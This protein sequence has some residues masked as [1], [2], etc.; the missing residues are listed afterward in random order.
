[1]KI[2][3][4]EEHFLTPMYREH[5]SATEYRNFYLSSRGEA[6]GHDIVEQNLDLGGQRIAH[7]DAAGVDM[8]VLSFGSPGPQ[9]FAAEVAIP[10]ARD[11][12]QRLFETISDLTL[13]Q[14]L[15]IRQLDHEPLQ[16]GQVGQGALH[17][18]RVLRIDDRRRH[19]AMRRGH[20]VN[21]GRVVGAAAAGAR[22]NAPKLVD[23][24]GSRH[25]QQP[26]PHSAARGV[27]ACRLSPRLREHFLDDVLGVAFVVDDSEDE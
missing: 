17:Q 7:M 16:Q 12:N 5:V 15:E 24:S 22:A 25:H 26:C 9:A 10:M 1:M 8:Q 18:P 19:I 21:R 6:M 13:G 2:I 4:I 23:R 3:A 27:V 11:A 20:I 14:S